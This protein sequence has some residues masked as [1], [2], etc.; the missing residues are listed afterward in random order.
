[1]SDRL[2]VMES[3]L[4]IQGEGYHQ[5]VLAYFI[6]LSG[7]DVGCPWCDVKESWQV[8][9]SQWRD[10]GEIISEIKETEA[11]TIIVT[12]GEPLMYDLK[13]LTNKLHEEGF[14]IHIETSGAYPLSGNF[15]WITLSPKKFKEPLN[16]LYS[17]ANELKVIV[18]SKKDFEWAEAEA[19]K[20][21]P[22]CHLYLQ[23]EWDR[24]EKQYPRIYYY[25]A[26]HPIWKISIQTHKY[27][28]LP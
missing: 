27:L 25:I 18:A 24:K 14:K 7:C 22:E 15:D 21:K 12:G 16:E 26:E 13:P 2:P 1:M 3:F 17:K 4:S 9:D 28:G 20:V 10:I 19:L 8:E 23:A 6:R 11:Q 5:G